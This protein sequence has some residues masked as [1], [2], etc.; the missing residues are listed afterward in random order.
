MAISVEDLAAIVGR[1]PGPL[2]SAAIVGA[3]AASNTIV[4]A[5]AGRRIWL[6]RFL[7]VP[8][9]GVHTFQWR[10]NATPLSGVE[11]LSANLL[12]TMQ[13][14]F[15]VNDG[16]PLIWFQTAA[17]NTFGGTAWWRYV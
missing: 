2:Q 13:D 16:E 15:T 12:Y 17:L 4:A 3:A 11:T 8:Q 10:S 5:M 6:E 9:T 7:G 14:L 1:N